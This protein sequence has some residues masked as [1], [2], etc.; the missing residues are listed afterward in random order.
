MKYFRTKE[1]ECKC[2]QCTSA[3]SAQAMP[4]EVQANIDALV[5]NVLDPLREAYGYPVFVNSGYRCEKHNK[6]VG[7][8]PNSQHMKGEAAD[9]HPMQL[10]GL[11]PQEVLQEL[12]RLI[13]KRGCFDQ[14]ILYPTFIHV[15]WKRSGENRHKILRKTTTGYIELTA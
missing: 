6:A 8:V 3:G 12:A 4:S 7:G 11:S 13:A 14:M 1:F 10:P 15:S 9:I 5:N 2:G